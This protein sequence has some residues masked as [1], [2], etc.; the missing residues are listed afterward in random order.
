MKLGINMR[1][2][3]VF[4]I[5][6]EEH[7]LLASFPRTTLETAISGTK[8]TL[9]EV[10]MQGREGCLL[11]AYQGDLEEVPHDTLYALR[12]LSYD[13]TPAGQEQDDITYLLERELSSI[14]EGDS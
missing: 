8:V 13:M 4:L 3:S 9:G 14:L 7:S 5:L 12:A 6:D 2:P 11:L 1:A 10:T